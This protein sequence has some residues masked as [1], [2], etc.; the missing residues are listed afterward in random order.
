MK[1]TF[2]DEMP[3]QMLKKLVE[4]EIMVATESAKI[5][6]KGFYFDNDLYYNEVENGESEGLYE[7]I[8]AIIEKNGKPSRWILVW[9]CEGKEFVSFMED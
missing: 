7:H 6:I 4:R 2:I 5:E 8:Y 1:F 9:D 3:L